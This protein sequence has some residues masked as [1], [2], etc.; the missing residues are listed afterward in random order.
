MENRLRK[1]AIIKKVAAECVLLMCCCVPEK[2]RK[3]AAIE[4]Q[5]KDDIELDVL[6]DHQLNR[7]VQN[8]QVGN[9]TN[10]A[11]PPKHGFVEPQLRFLECW[12]IAGVCECSF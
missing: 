4:G 12:V 3:Q 1:K 5:I 6:I 8:W 2:L 11:F 9:G 7:F 10:V